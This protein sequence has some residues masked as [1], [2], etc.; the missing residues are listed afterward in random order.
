MLCCNGI[1]YG[2]LIQYLAACNLVY[3]QRIH[4]LAGSARNDH[5]VGVHL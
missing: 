4:D 3:R 1:N 5:Q 2:V